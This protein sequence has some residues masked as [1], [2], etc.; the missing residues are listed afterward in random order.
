MVRGRQGVVG[1]ITCQP[2][3]RDCEV[4]GSKNS[5]VL[6]QQVLQCNGSCF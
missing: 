2:K 5:R 6:E 1:A 3:N 4:G